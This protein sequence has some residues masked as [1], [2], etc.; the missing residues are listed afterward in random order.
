MVR[1]LKKNYNS[2]E[3]FYDR[4]TESYRRTPKQYKGSETI[5][6]CENMK[7]NIDILNLDEELKINGM[8]K[9]YIFLGKYQNK[10]NDLEFD[11]SCYYTKKDINKNIEIHSNLELNNENIKEIV[12]YFN[13]K[14]YSVLTADQKEI[15]ISEK[16]K[17]EKNAKFINNKLQ[18]K[19]MQNAINKVNQV[20]PISF[21]KEQVFYGT[22]KNREMTVTRFYDNNIIISLM[23]FPS[24][25]EVYEIADYFGIYSYEVFEDIVG[26]DKMTRIEE[27]YVNDY[28]KITEDEKISEILEK[29]K[30][31]Y[32]DYVFE[33]TQFFNFFLL[34]Y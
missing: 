29:I 6:P 33:Y 14:D 13:I 30:M 15:L 7:R 31:D 27:T 32:E 24:K 12:E 34:G 28:Y 9:K 17:K 10:K 26:G 5:I 22:Y 4:F 1:K 8:V 23:G 25:K 21:E 19:G 20:K 11:F 2:N 16:N 18:Q 3:E